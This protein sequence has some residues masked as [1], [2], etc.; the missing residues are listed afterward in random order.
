MSAFADEPDHFARWLA[1]LPDAERSAAGERG[2]AGTF[3]RRQVY[4]AYIT[5]LL[6]DSITRLGGGRNLY[7]ITDE[8]TG[9]HSTGGGFRLATAGGRSYEVD[10]AVLA[11]GNFPPDRSEAPGH[12]GDPWHP[13]CGSRSCAGPARAADRHRAHHGRRLPG[14]V[15]ARL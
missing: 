12:D 8:A 2:F 4:G 9:L 3:V 15:G 14:A 10:A 7:L 5:H 6:E 13:R 11:L 1:A